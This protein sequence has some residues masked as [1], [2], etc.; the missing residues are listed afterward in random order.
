MYFVFKDDIIAW[1]DRIL[2]AEFQG[3]I[4]SP[5]YQDQWWE[6][7]SLTPPP[8]LTFAINAEAPLLD[9][10]FTGSLI[11]LYSVRLISYLR[12]AKVHFESFP[13]TVVDHRTKQLLPVQ[14]EVFHL[15]EIHP[16]LDKELSDM[17]E[18]E[19]RR[20][21]LTE[22]CVQANK[23]LFRL[24]ESKDIV[25]IHQDLRTTLDTANIT[26]CRFT[27]VDEFRVDLVFR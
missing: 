21:V 10:Y 24:K 15:M 9:N 25:L 8:R 14:Y 17:D 20:L 26:G 4:P 13:A 12:E 11:D 23:P 5:E 1:R 16:G 22:A 6:D 19:I 3:E 7:E 18:F 2:Q 27:A